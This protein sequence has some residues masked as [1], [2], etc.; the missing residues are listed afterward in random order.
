MIPTR[1]AVG[2]TCVEQFLGCCRI[3]QRDANRLC[4]LQRK[5][6]VFLVQLD[7]ETGIEGAEGML[8]M[9]NLTVMRGDDESFSYTISSVVM[10]KIESEK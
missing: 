10:K 7:A 3:G 5:V 4:T 9:V 8:K 6:Q 1:T 2:G